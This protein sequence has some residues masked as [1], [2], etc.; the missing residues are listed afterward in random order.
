MAMFHEYRRSIASLVLLIAWATMPTQAQVIATG[1]LRATMWEGQLT[2]LIS[3]DSLA[4]AGTF[5]LGP[6]E[7]LQGEI[8]L[9]DGRSFISYME[10]DSTVVVE[11]QMQV[12]APFF[13]HQLVAEWE[14]VALA[15]KVIDLPSLDA[16][17]SKRFVDR[18]APFFFRLRGKVTEGTAHVMDVPPG[19]TINGPSDAHF[20]QKH[21]TVKAAEVELIGVFSTK[22][23]TVFTHHDSN[24][25]VHLITADRALMGHLDQ[26]RMDPGTMRLEVAL[27]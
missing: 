2:G 24:I 7:Y 13:V 14:E 10:N 17:L 20:S 6:L 9:M 15:D 23:K 3:M 19:T 12:S 16:F 5:G 8:T 21:F 25:H 18:E 26:L 22:H 27:P 11:E 1:S 4:V